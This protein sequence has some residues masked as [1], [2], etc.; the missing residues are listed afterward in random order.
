LLEYANSQLL[1]FRHYDDLL[2]EELER[3][4]K[5]LDEGTG[6]FAQWRLARSA[7]RLHTVLLDADGED[8]DVVFLA[9]GFGGVGDVEGGLV[10]Q[11]VDAVEAE[12]LAGG[13]RA[14]TTP[15]DRAGC[16]RRG[17]GR[18]GPPRR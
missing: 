6:V 11:V 13:W 4:Y 2:T 3:V 12:E 15:S 7:T 18:G 10:A 5:L 16:G 1:E 14:S 9:E 17:A 8:G